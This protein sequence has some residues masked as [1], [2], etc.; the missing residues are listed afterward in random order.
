VVGSVYLALAA[1]LGLAVVVLMMSIPSEDRGLGSRLL[2]GFMCALGWSFFAWCG[3]GV[4][5]SSKD[6]W[7]DFFRRLEVDPVARQLRVWIDG[8]FAWQRSHDT[9]PF[10][11]LRAVHATLRPQYPIHY[12]EDQPCL[13]LRLDIE[14][15]GARPVSA[16]LRAR[17]VERPEHATELV[18]QLGRALRMGQLVTERDEKGD[19]RFTLLPEGDGSTLRASGGTLVDTAP[20]PEGFREPEPPLPRFAP[21]TP[22]LQGNWREWTPG[23][24]V[25][26][27]SPFSFWRELLDAWKSGV[28][29]LAVG[30]LLMGALFP[31]ETSAWPLLGFVGCGLLGALLS[32]LVSSWRAPPRSVELRWAERAVHAR[33]FGRSQ[34]IPFSRIRAVVLGG[35]VAQR[36]RV[37]SRVRPP[38]RP[39]LR[40]WRWLLVHLELDDGST[41]P[42]FHAS[43]QEE[44]F[45]LEEHGLPLA[46]DLARA[47]GVP[48]R[49]QEFV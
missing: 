20:L 41:L 22:H 30:G 49:R 42:L 28:A 40:Y 10:A 46:V 19:P 8:Y 9:I 16:V 47:L 24:R 3:W 6:G 11:A 44:A 29:G 48:W 34:V 37:G 39:P 17:A 21:D 31:D 43:I 25:R 23:E 12:E 27:E 35:R 15:E 5:G 2:G 14:R 33:L 13:Q 18:R 45:G 4:L 36:S 32:A 7:S 38:M 26:A 1:L